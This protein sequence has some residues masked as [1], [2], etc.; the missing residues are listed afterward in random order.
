VAV[1]VDRGGCAL[2]SWKFTAGAI[3]PRVLD[4]KRAVVVKRKSQQH[5][6]GM[7]LPLSF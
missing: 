2:V 1:V 6:H 4:L 7:T 5:Q 3:T